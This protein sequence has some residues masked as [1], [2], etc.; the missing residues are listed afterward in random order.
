MTFDEWLAEGIRRG[1]VMEGASIWCAEHDPIPWRAGELAEIAAAG[2]D[3]DVC[4][5]PA[6]RMAL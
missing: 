2:G 5:A 1:F 3:E 4:C 6:L